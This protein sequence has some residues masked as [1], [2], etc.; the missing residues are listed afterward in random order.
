MVIYSRAV[1]T[2]KRRTLFLKR[3]ELVVHIQLNYAHD[4]VLLFFWARCI[5]Q[6]RETNPRRFWSRLSRLCC[7]SL[8][9]DRRGQSPSRCWHWPHVSEPVVWIFSSEH[10]RT[11]FCR[12]TL[13]SSWNAERWIMPTETAVLYVTHCRS[14]NL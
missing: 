4:L 13:V 1:A 5:I 2:I 10:G 8:A 3:S 7:C 14:S 11:A 9:S 12:N 6:V